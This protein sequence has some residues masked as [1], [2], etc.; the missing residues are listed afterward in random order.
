MSSTS[1]PLVARTWRG[2]TRAEDADAYLAYL[3][4]TGLR[5]YRATSGNRGV[6]VLRRAA[7]DRADFLLLTLWSSREAIRAFAGDDIE[8]AV[9][10]PEDERYLVA[11]D[12]HVEH[13][14]VVD[15]DAL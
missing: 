13:F 12:E 9:F 15:R 4:Q 1:P 8:R 2:S 10:Y 5:A 6:L 7:G 3:Q 11:R 14:D